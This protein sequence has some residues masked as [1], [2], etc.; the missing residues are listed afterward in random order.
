MIPLEWKGGPDGGDYR[1]QGVDYVVT[2]AYRPIDDRSYEIDVKV[3]G[4]RAAAARLTI[5]PDGRSITTVQTQPGPD[6]TYISTTT[7]YDRVSG[8]T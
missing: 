7:V 3:D 5:S 2:N 4:R 6:G 8:G 1:V